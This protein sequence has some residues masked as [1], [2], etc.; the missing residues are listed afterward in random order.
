VIVELRNYR[1]KAGRRAEFIQFFETRTAP[2]QREYGMKIVGP[3]LD[4]ENP[5]RFAWR[6]SFPSLAERD[7]MKTAF[8]G[9]E[10]FLKEFEPVVT[11]LLE[12]YDFG[13]YETSPGYLCDG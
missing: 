1:I 8:Y 11:S 10:L 13:L 6:R 9:S 4:L 7:R 5:N 2:A 3:F 12:S